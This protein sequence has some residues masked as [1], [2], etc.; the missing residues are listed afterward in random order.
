VVTHIDA[1]PVEDA[2]HPIP[3]LDTLDVHLS[4]DKGAYVGIVIATPLK[5]DDL[6][7][8]RLQ[9]KIEISLEYFLSSEYRA[10]HG[11]PCRTKSRLWINVHADTDAEML[12]LIEHYR[13]QI[14]ANNVS[15][16]VQLIGTN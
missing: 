6:S 10:L 1:G 3:R 5:N 14:E 11:A 2:N 15:A 13:V 7:K 9:R 4:T 8:A 16:I 12:A